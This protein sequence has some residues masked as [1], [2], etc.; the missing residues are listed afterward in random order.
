MQA[1]KR[2]AIFDLLKLYNTL[3]HAED[4]VVN[5]ATAIIAQYVATHGLDDCTPAL[6]QE[7]VD[8]NLDLMQYGIDQCKCSV[9]DYAVVKTY[10]IIKDERRT[11]YG[12]NLSTNQEMKFGGNEY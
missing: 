2:D 12:D 8:A 7:H 4:T 9:V 5:L 11:S 3:H 6:I 10:R 1:R